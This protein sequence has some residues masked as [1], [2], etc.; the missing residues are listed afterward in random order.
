T[1]IVAAAVPVDTPFDADA[2]HVASAAIA[3]AAA[4]ETKAL[5]AVRQSEIVAVPALAGRDD[6][7]ALCDRL[8]DVQEQLRQEGVA[9][10]IGVS[11]VADGV[12]DLPRAYLEARAALAGV[13]A[14][15]GGVALPRPP[16]A[17]SPP[18]GPA[19]PAPP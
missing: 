14:G 1:L 17:P 5:V 13:P 19:A 6:A 18:P 12:V 9:L 11:T 10:A 15:R 7:L 2:P 4:A 3:R 8:R 16:A